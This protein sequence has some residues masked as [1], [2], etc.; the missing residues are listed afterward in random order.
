MNDTTTSPDIL[1]PIF[2]YQSTFQNMAFR[3]P[4]VRCEQTRAK[5]NAWGFHQSAFIPR[6]KR[7]NGGSTPLLRRV[8]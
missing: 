4:A 2:L 8:A 6:E 1:H 5:W 7:A 3:G